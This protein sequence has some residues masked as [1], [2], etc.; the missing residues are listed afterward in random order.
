MAA[1]L[2]LNQIKELNNMDMTQNAL[3]ILSNTC[4]KVS[5]SPHG[6]ELR[7]LQSVFSGREYLWQR[8][9]ALWGKS[10]PVL[11]PLIGRVHDGKVTHHGRTYEITTPHGFAAHETF[12]VSDVTSTHVRFTLKASEQTRAQYPFLFSLYLDYTLE[13]DTL[14]VQYTVVNEDTDILPFSLGGHPG[15]HVPWLAGESFSDY[16]L[17]FSSPEEP[18]RLLLEG[19]FISDRRINF[20]LQ[21]RR[22]IPLSYPLFKDEAIILG[23]IHDRHV[24]LA[25][26][27]NAVKL[28]FSFPDFPYLGIWTPQD[29]YAELLC[30]E[31]WHGL[32][33][34]CSWTEDVL[35]EKPDSILLASGKTFTA[36]WSVK[37][38]E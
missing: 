38:M 3:V 26:K 4:L 36:R 18:Q 13:D 31:P 12:M 6:A 16:Y 30:L 34:P 27:K 8:D 7:S 5:I 21:E 1:N 32:P 29:K 25:S 17:E 15:F 23:A 2:H 22:K 20:P 10:S 11:F 24:T 14:N 37:V 9:S 33:S 35:E 19:V 28:L